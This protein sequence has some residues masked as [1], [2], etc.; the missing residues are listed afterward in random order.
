MAFVRTG[1]IIVALVL[2]WGA[3]RAHPVGLTDLVVP[4][5]Q[6]AP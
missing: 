6:P 1:L 3:V 4:T 5:A 2:G